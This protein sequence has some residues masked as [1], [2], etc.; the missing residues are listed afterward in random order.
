MGL[1]SVAVGRTSAALRVGPCPSSEA[2]ESLDIRQ[3]S[4][5]AADCAGYAPTAQPVTVDV[6][7]WQEVS[8]TGVG[9]CTSNVFTAEVF[10]RAPD[11]T[12]GCVDSAFTDFPPPHHSIK[13]AYDPQ[14]LLRDAHNLRA[15]FCCR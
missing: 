4:L 13:C 1:L 10:G 15:R 14:P 9:G 11:A 7:R 3:R 8:C 5:A 12:S 6:R 2:S